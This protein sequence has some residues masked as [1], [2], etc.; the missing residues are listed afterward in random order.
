[1]SEVSERY[2]RLAD[3]FTEKVVAVPTERWTSPSP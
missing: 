3:A 2:A 1:M